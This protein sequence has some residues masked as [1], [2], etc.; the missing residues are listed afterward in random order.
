[1]TIKKLKQRQKALNV[2]SVAISGKTKVKQG[3]I[4]LAYDV[5]DNGFGDYV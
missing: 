1:M 5:L 2:Q 4:E 3:D